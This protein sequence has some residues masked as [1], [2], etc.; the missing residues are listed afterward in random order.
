MNTERDFDRMPWAWLDLMPDE[1][2]DRVIDAVLGGHDRAIGAAGNSSAA[3]GSRAPSVCPPP[4]R[5]SCCSV[6]LLAAAV[7]SACLGGGG[8]GFPAVVPATPAAP[9]RQRRPCTAGTGT[10]LTADPHRDPSRRASGRLRIAEWQPDGRRPHPRPPGLAPTAISLARPHARLDHPD[11]SRDGSMLAYDS[12]GSPDEASPSFDRID[13][14][15][16]DADGANARQLSP[17]SHRASSAPCRRPD[18]DRV[19]DDPLRPHARP[20]RGW[21]RRPR[22][23]PPATSGL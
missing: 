7:G 1:A 2:P 10:V 14:W 6:R 20:G 18:G 12:G 23:S 15:I 8:Q 13:I 17:A 5:S 22:I 16:S 11:W 3:G 19:G 4:W 9:R 21:C